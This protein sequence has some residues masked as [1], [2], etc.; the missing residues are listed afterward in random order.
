ML[1]GLAASLVVTAA[2]VS[3]APTAGER[4]G[5]TPRVTLAMLPGPTTISELEAAAP[6]ASLGILSAGLGRVAA[7]QT[8]L[9][10]SQG[11]RLF[12]SLYP[13]DLGPASLRRDRVPPADWRAIVQ[14]A[15]G[16]PAALEPGLLADRLRDLGVRSAADLEAGRAQLIAVDGRGRIARP[17]RCPIAR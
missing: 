5:P 13:S 12:D 14:R 2:P 4:A 17:G 16:A 3:A 15:D 8:Y 1:A 10:I 9:D 6:G 7:E 11:N